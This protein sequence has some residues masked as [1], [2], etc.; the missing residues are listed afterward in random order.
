MELNNSNTD[1]EPISQQVRYRWF[2]DLGSSPTFQTTSA[3]CVSRYYCVFC[4]MWL[5]QKSSR[6]KFVCLVPHLIKTKS[7]QGTKI[8]AKAASWSWNWLAITNRKQLSPWALSRNSPQGDG[9][10]SKNKRSRLRQLR[11]QNGSLWS[12]G[13]W[14]QALAINISFYTSGFLADC[15]NRVASCNRM[16]SFEASDYP[17]LK[18]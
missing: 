13:Y 1:S 15:S 16:C 6:S 4:K 11:G 3:Q 8:V 2:Q 14:F 18:D 12:D 5:L 17:G 9:G 7:R 10:S